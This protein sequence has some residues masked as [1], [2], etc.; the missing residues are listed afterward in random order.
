MIPP[1]L[2]ATVD[3]RPLV[4]FYSAGF[5]KKQDPAALDYLREEFEKDFGVEPFIVKEVSWEGRADAVFA[6]GAAL[7]PNFIDVAAVGP[8]YDHSAVPG[9]APL[10]REREDGAF[11]CRAWE[12]ALSF[13][14]ESRPR[15]AIVETWN[16]FHEGT[17]IAPTKEHGRKYVELTRKYADLWRAGKRLQRPGPYARAREVSL[18]LGKANEER[19]LVQREHDDGRT[20]P[21]HAVGKGGRRTVAA[22]R[23]G[24]YIY[25]DADDSFFLRDALPLEVEFTYLDQGKGAISFEYDSSDASAHHAGAFKAAAPVALKGSGAWRTAAIRLS[26][27]AF[28]GRANGSDFRLSVPGGDLTLHRVEIRKIGK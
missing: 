3:G 23:G 12:T 22:G 25:F 20:E 28:T 6:W 21:C 13:D 14:P 1:D 17:E 2:W 4:W 24:R 19:G 8:G 18:V 16:E 26:D 11:Y 10:V 7:K 15:L 5:A 9:R 27:A